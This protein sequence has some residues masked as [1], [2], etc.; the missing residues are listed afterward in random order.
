M[1]TYQFIEP[2][3]QNITALQ[4]ALND[5]DCS[6]QEAHENVA[7][8]ARAIKALLTLPDSVDM[9]LSIRR[10]CN[11]IFEQSFDGMNEANAKAEE[12]GANHINERDRSEESAICAAI[13]YD[14]KGVAN[15]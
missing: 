2:T 13:R 12:F 3:K 14:G 7:A 8:A 4:S 11:Q 10:L 15:V 6:V 9:R 1:A 5:V